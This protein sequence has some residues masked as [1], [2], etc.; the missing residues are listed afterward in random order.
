MEG[1]LLAAAALAQAIMLRC[2]DPK[3]AAAAA[4]ALQLEAVA[5]ADGGDRESAALLMVYARG[6][7]GQAH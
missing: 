4:E 6:L 1:K 7:R 5:L 3:G 2:S